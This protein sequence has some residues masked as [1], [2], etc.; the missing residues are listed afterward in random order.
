[1]QDDTIKQTTA[2]QEAHLPVTHEIMSAALHVAGMSAGA[3]ALGDNLAAVKRALFAAADMARELESRATVE[4]SPEYRLFETYYTVQIPTFLPYPPN[5]AE[6]EEASIC[7]RFPVRK[8]A[9]RWPLVYLAAPYAHTNPTVRDMRAQEATACA[10]WL[11]RQGIGVFSPLTHGHPIGITL[12]PTTY[13]DWALVDERVLAACD[14]VLVLDLPGATASEGVRRELE[15]A[16]RMGIPARSIHRYT[17]DAYLVSS[18]PAVF[19]WDG[20]PGGCH[21][22]A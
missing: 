9:S 19:G 6:V 2:T 1:M 7:V 21:G 14:A 18:L 10:A 3:G 12:G 17:S 16:R 8:S 22:W 13:D 4:A 20:N 15:L 5:W 11:M